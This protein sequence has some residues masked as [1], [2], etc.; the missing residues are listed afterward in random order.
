MAKKSRSK[1][2]VTPIVA[3]YDGDGYD[4]EY[5][6]GTYGKK[7]DGRPD[8]SV[9]LKAGV[10]AEKSRPIY[11]LGKLV[12]PKG[13]K[14]IIDDHFLLHA[15]PKKRLK[16]IEVDGFLIPSTGIARKLFE[17]GCFEV[18]PATDAEIE[19]AKSGEFWYNAEPPYGH[20]LEAPADVIV[21]EDKQPKRRGRPRKSSSGS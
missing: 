21:D 7:R 14:V 19:A 2:T 13:E 6:P 17:L 10:L 1:A 3:I 9:V 11:K 20:A 15:K 18:S 4:T 5:T 8:H 16:P 12:F